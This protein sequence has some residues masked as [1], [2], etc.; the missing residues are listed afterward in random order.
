[1]L[2]RI[3]LEVTE[4]VPRFQ[5]YLDDERADVEPFESIPEGLRYALRICP[6]CV[7]LDNHVEGCSLDPDP[8]EEVL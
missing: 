1:M 3:S 2:S 8:L 5:L 6:E 7:A 4:G